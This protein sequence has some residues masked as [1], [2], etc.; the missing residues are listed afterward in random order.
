MA[1]AVIW[2]PAVAEWRETLDDD[3]YQQVVAAVDTLAEHGPALRRPLVGEVQASRH[4]NMKELRPGSAGRSEV[5]ILFAFDPQRSAV[6]LVAGDKV[7]RW[8]R[9]YKNAVPLAD[10]RLDEHVERRRREDG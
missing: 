5:R 6:L 3:T 7:G 1:W 2:H 9:W 4:R 10:D 8:N